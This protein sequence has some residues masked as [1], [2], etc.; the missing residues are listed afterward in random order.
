MET[1]GVL[2]L[3]QELHSSERVGLFS[4]CSLNLLDALHHFAYLLVDLEI[5][6]VDGVQSGRTGILSM[7]IGFGEAG[8]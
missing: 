4:D 1:I 7:I 3:M 2:K 5:V 6:L 8:A